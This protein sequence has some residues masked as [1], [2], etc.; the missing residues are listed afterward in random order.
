MDF[1]VKDKDNML[2]HYD[3]K[4]NAE[5]GFVFRE[6]ANYLTK[7]VNFQQRD[8]SSQTIVVPE[9]KGIEALD[10]YVGI[11][12]C[13]FMAEGCFSGIK[14]LT[15]I[16]PSDNANAIIDLRA[17]DKGANVHFVTPLQSCAY[18]MENE[19][20]TFPNIVLATPKTM[21]N[22]PDFCPFYGIDRLNSFPHYIDKT[23]GS[24]FDCM[25]VDDYL[26]KQNLPQEET[27]H[28]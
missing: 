9:L 4:G 19:G 1:Y 13:V 18:L 10:S 3:E 5:Y 27:I 25:S 15:I 22:V 20:F 24:T 26:Q 21:K 16:V 11:H 7:F 2:V 14:D 23:G 28:L 6:R 8:D 12:S 17:F